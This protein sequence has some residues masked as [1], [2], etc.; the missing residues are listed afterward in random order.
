A[1]LGAHSATDEELAALQAL[2]ERLHD[3]AAQRD[4]EQIVDLDLRFHLAVCR[5]AQSKR[6]LEAWCRMDRMRRAFLLRKYALYDDSALIA[7][8]HQPILDALQQRDA[9]RAARLLRTHIL[10]TAERVLDGL[11]QEQ[12]VTS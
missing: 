8:S 11:E 5:L 7:G 2:I 6:L 9:D 4:F 12:R 3:A 1:R 10:D